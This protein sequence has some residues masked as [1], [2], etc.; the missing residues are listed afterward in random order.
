MRFQSNLNYFCCT[1]KK[2]TAT[3]HINHTSKINTE[4]TIT[5]TI[6]LNSLFTPSQSQESHSH[7]HVVTHAPE[8]SL[9]SLSHQ[10]LMS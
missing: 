5:T 3:L 7:R 4:P 6:E 8:L 2:I 10:S 9:G 1:A